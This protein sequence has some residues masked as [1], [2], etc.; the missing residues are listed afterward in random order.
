MKVLLIPG[1]ASKK[2][3]YFFLGGGGGLFLGWT[4]LV[5]VRECRSGYQILLTHLKH[6][7]I[8]S[9]FCFPST[10]LLRVIFICTKHTST[11]LIYLLMNRCS[12]IF[13][14]SPRC[15]WCPVTI[16]RKRH[17]SVGRLNLDL[18]GTNVYYSLFVTVHPIRCASFVLVHKYAVGKG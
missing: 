8:F 1:E 2:K 16:P 9:L 14:S 18:Y 15:P 17:Y 4:S 3:S 12:S 7:N 10:F 13:N 5:P 6:R 11:F